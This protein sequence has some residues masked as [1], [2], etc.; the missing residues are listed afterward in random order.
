M[1]LSVDCFLSKVNAC[2]LAKSTYY[3]VQPINMNNTTDD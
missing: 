2:R 3:K 1:K